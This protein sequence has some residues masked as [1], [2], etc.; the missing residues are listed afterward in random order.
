MNTKMFK[1][2]RGAIKLFVNKL[3]EIMIDIEVLLL[4]YHH[5]YVVFPVTG[6]HSFQSKFFT[7]SDLVLRLSSS[8]IFFFF[9]VYPVAVLVSLIIPSLLPYL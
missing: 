4:E 5:Y 8:S 3:V 9:K 7:K 6:P 1:M 2:N